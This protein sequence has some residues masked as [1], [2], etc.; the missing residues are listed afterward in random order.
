[1]ASMGKEAES[2]LE[3]FS[4][5]RFAD[6][7]GGDTVQD[8]FDF[9]K[10]EFYPE[11]RERKEDERAC[12]VFAE[13]VADAVSRKTPREWRRLFRRLGFR[14]MYGRT[15]IWADSRPEYPILLWRVA[16]DWRQG[17]SWATDAR[18]CHSH[19]V[20]HG[21]KSTGT[22]W[23]SVVP[24]EAVLGIVWY[25]RGAAAGAAPLWRTVDLPAHGRV[26]VAVDDSAEVIV[27]STKLTNSERIEV[28]G[29]TSMYRFEHLYADV[30]DMLAK[31]VVGA[32]WAGSAVGGSV[33]A[34]TT[35]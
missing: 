11:V 12:R 17:L 2:V 16:D 33:G 8:E 3:W 14:A 23:C 26:I 32:A 34:V 20:L 6:S 25:E 30:P 22:L 21:G 9:V 13:F 10:H 35:M 4:G 18:S 31:K 1:M 24:P 5:R 19:L 27:D 15:V 28:G 29:V 7:L